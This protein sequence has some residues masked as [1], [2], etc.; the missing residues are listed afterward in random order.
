MKLAGEPKVEVRIVDEYGQ[1]GTP[2]VHLRHHVPEHLAQPTEMAHHL[3]QADHRE[4]ADVRHQGGA[5]SLKLVSPEA[6][7]LQVAQ[8]GAEVPDQLGAVQLARR[9]AARNQE[10]V[11]GMCGRQASSIANTPGSDGALSRPSVS[12]RALAC[13]PR[14][15]TGGGRTSRANP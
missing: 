1:A 3:E 9:L 10:P 4:V 11:A 15:G 8:L 7:H 13:C 14:R 6:E 5:L 2:P 12:Y